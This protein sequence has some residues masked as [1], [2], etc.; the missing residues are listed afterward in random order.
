MNQEMAHS[1]KGA[2]LAKPHCAQATTE[3]AEHRSVFR[4]DY[5]EFNPKKGCVVVWLV[6]EAGR[7]QAFRNHATVLSNVAHEAKDMEP[8]AGRQ[9]S[10]SQRF[11]LPP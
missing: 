11:P 1:R 9:H 10:S 6:R 3:L 2:V 5:N 4:L 7:S 8:T